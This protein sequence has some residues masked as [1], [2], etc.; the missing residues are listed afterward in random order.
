[1]DPH[2]CPR[3]HPRAGMTEDELLE[4]WVAERPIYEAWGHYVVEQISQR[5]VEKLPAV[6]IDMFIRIPPK[7]R[8]KEDFS[9]VEKAF[10]RK[11]YDDPYAQIT[12]K[13]G[14]RLVVLLGTD[15]DV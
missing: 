12:D 2:H 9:F 7:V 14:I 10:Y 8:L 1:M 15:L 3:S 6:G 4:K 13:V 5:L 11:A